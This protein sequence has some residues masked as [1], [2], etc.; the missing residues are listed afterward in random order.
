MRIRGRRRAAVESGL[1]SSV[2]NEGASED[3]EGAVK[4]GGWRG[5]W[6]R[7]LLLLLGL[8]KAFKTWPGVM[9]EDNLQAGRATMDGGL[10]RKESHR[11]EARSP[12]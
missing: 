5:R 8:V 9:R 3:Q 7:L 6:G 10:G 4:E 12:H 2:Q 11:G 1:A